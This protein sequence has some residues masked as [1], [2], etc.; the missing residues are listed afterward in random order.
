MCNLPCCPVPCCQGELG[1][2]SK[3]I[4]ETY[5]Y[6]S[7][8]CLVNVLPG[9]SPIIQCVPPSRSPL[10]H[11]WRRRTRALFLSFVRPSGGRGGRPLPPRP[12]C[13]CAACCLS[14]SVVSEAS[15]VKGD[16]VVFGGSACA[17]NLAGGFEENLK[18]LM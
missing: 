3:I 10:S 8:C 11:L 13:A 6:S 12:P 17:W 2:L 5:L 1:E 14:P 15:R 16:P 4:Y 7:F 9:R 18:E